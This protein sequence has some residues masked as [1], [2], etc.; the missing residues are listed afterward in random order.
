MAPRLTHRDLAVIGHRDDL[1]LPAWGGQRRCRL[2]ILVQWGFDLEPA[3]A[4][5]GQVRQER[6][7]RRALKAL[8]VVEV[9]M[10]SRAACSASSPASGEEAEC[11]AGSNADSNAGSAAVGVIGLAVVGAEDAEAPEMGES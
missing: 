3:S 6:V 11:S 2:L 4:A 7:G 1:G 8:E 5:G 9:L 10:L